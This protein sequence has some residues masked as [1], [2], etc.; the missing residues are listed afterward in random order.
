MNNNDLSLILNT[1]VAIVV[2]ET[3]DEARTIELLRDLFRTASLPSW[4]WSFTEGLA[5]LGFGLELAN[6]EQYADP[7]VALNYIK[8][9]RKPGAFVL[10][11]I[12]P[13]L[14]TPKIVRLLKDIAL[15]YGVAKHRLVLV[16]H[17]LDLPPELSRHGAS[18]SISMP[19]EDEIL[20]IIREQARDWAERNHKN[21]IKTD[22]QTLQKLVNNLKGL[23]HQDVRRLAYGAIADDGAITEA[24][25]PEVTKAKFALMNMEGVLHFEYSTAHMRDVAGLHNLKKWLEHRQHAISNDDTK[26]DPP[27][28]VLLFGVQG[29]GKSLA[30]K[31]IAGVWGLPLLRLDMA[32]LFNKYIGET[33]RN[34]REALKLA[35]LMAPCVL[36][37]DEI[38]KGMA[39]GNDDNGTPKRL[40][41]TL[42]TWMA[43]RKS[44]VFM[45][46]TSNDIS[47]LPPE[48]MRKGRFDEIF[49]IDLPDHQ[50]RFHIFTIHLNKRELEPSHYNL[51]AMAQLTEGFTGAEIE[52]AVVSA[53]YS[54]AA[55][56]TQVS[57]ELLQAAI[58][59]TQPLSIVMAE[60]IEQLQAWAKERAVKA[61]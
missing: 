24:D 15:Q 30:A 56:G 35:D 10:C 14:D 48:L 33:E 53:T 18:V 55:R 31:A 13:F 28:G 8:Q 4:R 40:L 60:K 12:H 7:E 21:K 61:N 36:W 26:L 23:P 45:V 46:A 17:R 47:Q 37:L 29:G 43:E 3:W 41:G 5:P 22:N 32:A 38:E 50:T 19:S 49:F 52:Q 1:N 54:A 9:Y 34:L 27:K 6:P 44:R 11:D 59:Q 39:D 2:V 51:D 57:P 16:S 58:Q 20:A 42:L 25:L